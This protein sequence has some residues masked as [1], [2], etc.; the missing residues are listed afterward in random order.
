MKWI[1]LVAVSL[2]WTALAFAETGSRFG[3]LRMATMEERE[4]ACPP[5]AD[6]M[7][8]IYVLRN[9]LPADTD[10]ENAE[11]FMGKAFDSELLA[12]N[13][14]ENPDMSFLSEEDFQQFFLSNMEY[15]W[16]IPHQDE[17][18]F[19]DEEKAQDILDFHEDMPLECMEGLEVTP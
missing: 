18:G 2:V 15:V 14:E 10:S 19:T 6:L 9:L 16:G 17:Y 7:T 12:Q 1:A 5:Y 8:A 4:V 13:E 11:Y 3:K